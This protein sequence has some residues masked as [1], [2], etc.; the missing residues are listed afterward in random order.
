M[1]LRIWN[2]KSHRDGKKKKKGKKKGKQM[3]MRILDDD[4]GQTSDTSD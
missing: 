1:H 4:D 3:R 2:L